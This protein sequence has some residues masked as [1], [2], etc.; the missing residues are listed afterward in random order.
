[1]NQVNRKRDKTK[2]KELFDI[3]Y[4]ALSVGWHLRRLVEINPH[5]IANN[6]HEF[7]AWLERHKVKWTQK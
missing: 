3:F 6:H 1:M 7:M 4:N 2:E 5:F